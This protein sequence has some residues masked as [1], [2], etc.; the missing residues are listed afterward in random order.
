MI[1]T[2]TSIPFHRWRTRTKSNPE[3]F[4]YSTQTEHKPNFFKVLRTRTESNPY[5]QRTQTHN[6]GFFPIST[7]NPI[8]TLA[9]PDKSS[10]SDTIIFF[11]QIA[12]LKL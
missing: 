3:P 2:L 8:Q 12:D 4:I 1:I 9:Y 11:I 5:P 7:L 6:F 10:P